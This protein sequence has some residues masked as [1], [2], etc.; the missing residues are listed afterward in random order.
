MTFLQPSILLGLP[1]ILLPV[2]IHL[3]NRRRYRVQS[4]A[5]M[6]FLVLATRSST[7]RA[8]LKQFLILLFRTLA[9]LCLILFL[10]R[11]LVGSWMGWATGGAPNTV[12][13]LF[14]RSPSMDRASEDGANSLRAEAARLLTEAARPFENK[15]EFIF[16]ESGRVVPQRLPSPSAI[17]EESLTGPIDAAADI[18][19][20][21][22]SAMN[23]IQDNSPG[24][25]EVWIASD[26]QRSNW[27][28]EDSRWELIRER[29]EEA[30]QPIQ[31]RIMRLNADV[32][33]NLSIDVRR[34]RRL[35]DRLQLE[36]EFRAT[37]PAP[38]PT[39]VT[40]EI[41][42]VESVSE[43]QVD[44]ERTTWRPELPIAEDTGSGWGVAAI[45]ADNSPTDDRAY[46]LF[47]SGKSGS[48][49]LVGDPTESLRRLE[50]AALALTAGDPEATVQQFNSP[51]EL[52]LA[53][54]SL[55]LWARPL[56]SG[57]A[58]ETVEAF[59][60]EGGVVLFFPPGRE[61]ATT[62]LGARWDGA[63]QIANESAPFSIQSWNQSEGLWRNSDEGLNLPIDELEFSKRQRI[64]GASA[65]L[66]SY[67]DG[68]AALTRTSLGSGSFYC[69]ATRPEPEWSTLGSGVALIPALSRALADGARRLEALE[70][71]EC[72]ALSASAAQRSWRRVSDSEPGDPQ[73][74]A[75]VY[76]DGARLMAVNRPEKE[77]DDILLDEESVQALMGDIPV[78]QAE[79]TSQRGAQES[80]SS[81]I[82]RLFLT[83]MLGFLMAESVLTLPPKRLESEAASL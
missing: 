46:F 19:A 39:Q 77:Y 34:A 45:P 64:S 12:M 73:L 68:P 58:A 23:W 70:T 67:V 40:F 62:F 16:I 52:D 48:V 63:P 53:D 49:V 32:S 6:R 44:S 7:S 10:G 33:Q 66:A 29:V 37:G 72:G 78:S 25:T 76:Q 26:L 43:T 9:T 54:A 81:E 55:L 71:Y 38:G 21:A 83:V 80:A 65:V 35:R 57:G 1:L 56:P 51:L 14:D 36:I 11:P 42:G 74:F 69:F 3:L 60:R 22:L 20:M 5:A 50:F 24:V 59:I 82:W 30:P 2:L 28:P 41:D 4:W 75:G 18:P 47:G 31:F 13:I 8:K 27:A 15:S 61:D 79:F 17:S